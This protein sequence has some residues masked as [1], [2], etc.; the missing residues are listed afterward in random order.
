MTVS[1]SSSPRYRGLTARDLALIALFAA[2]LAAMSLVPGIPVGSVPITLQT[3]IVMLAPAILGAKRGVLAIATF[4][5]LALAGLPILS[6]GG[7]GLA[8]FAGPS[9]GFLISWI[10]VAL[11]IGLLTDRMLPAYRF[12]PGLL[13]NLVGGIGVCYL[14]G[15]PWMAV[16]AGL[17]ATAALIAL[18]AFVPG[19][20]I[21]AVVATLIAASVHRA[22]P[23]PPA[24]HRVS[25]A[26][27]RS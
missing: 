17:D 20:V 11:V 21:K 16:V 23:V 6:G 10:F 12:W 4:L 8:S 22:Y 7:G 14:I 26:G 13:I 2:L 15:G 19:D 24:G 1:P 27:P 25:A 3:L 18:A 9:G 5:A